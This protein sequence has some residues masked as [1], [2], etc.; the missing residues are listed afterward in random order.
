MYTEKRGRGTILV[1]IE[2]TTVAG[3]TN[4]RLH[5]QLDGAE[6]VRPVRVNFMANVYRGRRAETNCNRE[7]MYDWNKF[8]SAR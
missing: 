8:R 6:V 3:G 1:A 7:E 2:S 5:R 4:A